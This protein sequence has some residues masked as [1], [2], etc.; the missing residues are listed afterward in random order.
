MGRSRLPPACMLRWPPTLA[1]CGRP[2]SIEIDRRGLV[3]AEA[4]VWHGSN[5]QRQRRT[6]SGIVS[7]NEE[8]TVDGALVAV[9]G[10]ASRDQGWWVP[11]RAARGRGDPPADVVATR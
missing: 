8:F 1:S 3:N 10:V 4:C 11:Q 5:P 6:S 2:R 7:W 9:D